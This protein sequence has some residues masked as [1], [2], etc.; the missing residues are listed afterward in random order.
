M[1]SCKKIHTSQVKKRLD[2]LEKRVF[3]LERWRSSTTENES[4][5]QQLYFWSSLAIFVLAFIV[6]VYFRRGYEP[7]IL[8]GVIAPAAFQ[9]SL[10][11][12]SMARGFSSLLISIFSIFGTLVSSIIL[13]AST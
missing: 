6:T 3:A 2:N 4:S 5:Y 10:L 11:L 8:W 9:S 12:S 13:A 1:F 7:H